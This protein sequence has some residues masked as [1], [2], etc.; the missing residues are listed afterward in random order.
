MPGP[1]LSLP[2]IDPLAPECPQM[3]T[4]MKWP[5]PDGI[6]LYYC[7]PDFKDLVGKC[8]CRPG[9]KDK[10]EAQSVAGAQS[11]ANQVTALEPELR[12]YQVAIQEELRK[13]GT[14]A[15]PLA[16]LAPEAIYIALIGEPRAQKLDERMR[17]RG[18]EP[19]RNPV[20]GYHNLWVTLVGLTAAAY[21][22]VVMAPAALELAGSAAAGGVAGGGE[23]G[24]VLLFT[25]AAAAAAEPLAKAA[26]VLLIV[27][28]GTRAGEARAETV[29]AGAI[30]AVPISELTV[31]GSEPLGLGAS[32][33]HKGHR[34]VVV[35]FT[36]A[37]QGSP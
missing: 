34:F 1:P 3:L 23:A 11:A 35:G 10:S 15:Q 9:G 20:M 8:P 24:E 22:T 6:Y 2:F 14:A 28:A 4:V 19:R 18:L 37:Q 31:R 21:A 33:V 32:V 36:G 17:F 7:E 25:R 27:W 13:T 30:T 12:Q 5:Q 29:T 26:G 16:I